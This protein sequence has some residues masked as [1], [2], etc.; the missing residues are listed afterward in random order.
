MTEKGSG[1]SRFADLGIRAVSGVVLGLISLVCVVIGNLPAIL[2][3]AVLL[4]LLLWEYHR[5]VTGCVRLRAPELLV[6]QIGGVLGII[7]AG[8]QSIPIGFV[9]FTVAVL[10]AGLKAGKQFAFLA[11]GS[12]YIGIAIG[13]LLLLRLIH[14]NGFALLV[15][16]VCVVIAC[17]VAAYFAGRVFGGAKLCPRISPGKTRSG[18]LGGLVG[19]MVFSLGYGAVCGWPLGIAAGAALLVAA[20]SQVGDLVESWMKRRAGVK[21]SGILLPGHGGFLDRLDG[22][23]GGTW[24][25]MALDA[26]GLGIYLTN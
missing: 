6:L 26:L 1:S 20:A 22:V 7:V 24:A 11:L 14:P 19:A 18:G 16:L 17:D 10:V 5:I 8:L 25:F 13:Q 15:W 23:L 21:D 9:I 4:W 3:A 12:F 2:L